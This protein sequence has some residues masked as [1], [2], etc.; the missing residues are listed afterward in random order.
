MAEL[1]LNAGEFDRIGREAALREM[2]AGARQTVNRSK[3]LAPVDTGFLRASIREREDTGGTA[4]RID[5]VAYAD[6]ALPVHEGRGPVVIKP[7]RGHFL[8]FEVDGR[9]VY[10]REVHQP[11]R[12]ARPFL[13]RALRE[14]AS[15]RGWRFVNFGAL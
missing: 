2:R 14:V 8:K 9:T 13:S 15:S 3:V 4:L 6:Y 11:A 7:R 1:R 12:A 5:I 10:A